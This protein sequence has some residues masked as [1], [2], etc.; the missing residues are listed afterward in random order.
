MGN[1]I[2]AYRNAYRNARLW[3]KSV[4]FS[5]RYARTIVSRERVRSQHSVQ[6]SR[7]VSAVR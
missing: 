6:A 7:Q 4:R 3:N 1:T 5:I 2:N